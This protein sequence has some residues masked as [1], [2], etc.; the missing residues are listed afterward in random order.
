MI[1]LFSCCLEAKPLPDGNISLK[2]DPI[3]MINLFF[4]TPAKYAVG[5]G[6]D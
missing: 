6:Q 1:N 3:R 2:V 5:V 4:R